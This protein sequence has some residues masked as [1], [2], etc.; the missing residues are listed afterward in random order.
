MA[1]TPSSKTPV[2]SPARQ[3]RALVFPGEA[4]DVPL[5]EFLVEVSLKGDLFPVHELNDPR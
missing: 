2:I 5:M 1:T 3:T 4:N